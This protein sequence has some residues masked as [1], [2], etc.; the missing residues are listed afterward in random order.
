MHP[1]Q[2]GWSSCTLILEKKVT[3]ISTLTQAPFSSVALDTFGL[4]FKLI[5]HLHKDRG[6]E[7]NEWIGEKGRPESDVGIL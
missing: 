3:K 6:L 1:R 4:I 7:E 5:S 2:E